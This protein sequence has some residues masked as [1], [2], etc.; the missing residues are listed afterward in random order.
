MQR[1]GTRTPTNTAVWL[2]LDPLEADIVEDSVEGVICE[3]AV[4]V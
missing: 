2:V 4:G 3:S 1:R